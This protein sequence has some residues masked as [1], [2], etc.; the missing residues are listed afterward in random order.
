[1]FKKLKQ[2]RCTHEYEKGLDIG[3]NI[4]PIS[5]VNLYCSKCS[6]SIRVT[7]NMANKL[8]NNKEEK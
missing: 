7:S 6:H 2:A 4:D 3:F 1:M 8:I 5:M